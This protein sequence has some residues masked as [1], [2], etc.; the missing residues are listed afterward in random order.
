MSK[1]GKISKKL[2]VTKHGKMG[3]KINVFD[4]K[5]RLQRCILHAIASVKRYNYEL[6][7]A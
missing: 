3:I 4:T 7:H 5:N 2:V 6:C 1:R